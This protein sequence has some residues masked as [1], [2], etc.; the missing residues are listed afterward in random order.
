MFWTLLSIFTNVFENSLINTPI[1]VIVE[2]VQNK[3]VKQTMKGTE[4]FLAGLFDVLDDIPIISFF[5]PLLRLLT[6]QYSSNI[7][8]L[9][10]IFLSA[11]SILTIYS[12]YIT[13]KGD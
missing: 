4:S 9:I 6:F 8:P 13:I 5:T 7:H 10:S 2:D 12:I 1:N 3:E 11:I